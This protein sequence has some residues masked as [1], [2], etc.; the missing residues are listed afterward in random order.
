MGESTIIGK[1]AEVGEDFIVVELAE[2]V[3]GEYLK[4]YEFIIVEDPKGKSRVEIYL[5]SHQ[6]PRIEGG[7]WIITIDPAELSGFKKETIC[8]GA[9]VY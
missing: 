1:I 7:K 9:L 4:K 5:D 3:T 6:E 2:G 8:P